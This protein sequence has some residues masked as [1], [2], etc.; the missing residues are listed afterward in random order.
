MP[1]PGLSSQ[2]GA[3]THLHAA[4]RFEQ[5]G[6]KGGGGG[7]EGRGGGGANAFSEFSDGRGWL[8]RIQFAQIADMLKLQEHWLWASLGI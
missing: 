5:L 1:A 2:S 8:E 7:G 6:G 3:P 4:M